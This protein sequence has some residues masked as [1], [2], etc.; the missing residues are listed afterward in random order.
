LL[1]LKLETHV[2][3]L[4]VQ[5]SSIANH[6]IDN[7]IQDGND[8]FEDPPGARTVGNASR[9]GLR[10]HGGAGGNPQGQVSSE[11]VG[12]GSQSKCDLHLFKHLLQLQ[13]RK[14]NDQSSEARQ[15]GI[16]VASLQGHSYHKIRSDDL[17]TIAAGLV[18]AE[19]QCRRF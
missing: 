9:L 14:T 13:Y 8:E 3:H 5:L 19:H 17:Q 15:Q 11:A 10:L 1:P 12:H 7:S 16:L 18:A 6:R 4:S 2:A